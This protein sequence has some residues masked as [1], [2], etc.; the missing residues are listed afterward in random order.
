M[1]VDRWAP[2]KANTYQLNIRWKE[3][4]ITGK[5]GANIGYNGR[6]AILTHPH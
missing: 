3:Q 1:E 4:K 5:L 2:N 6:N